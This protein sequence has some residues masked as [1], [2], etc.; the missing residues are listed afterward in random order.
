MIFYLD[1]KYSTSQNVK[2]PEIV[3]PFLASEA[4]GYATP[5]LAFVFPHIFMK[6]T[7]IHKVLMK[8]KLV[9]KFPTICFD[10][11]RA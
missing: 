11:A 7:K 8:T 4:L 2:F 3:T 9:R 1:A 10:G 6:T 5:S